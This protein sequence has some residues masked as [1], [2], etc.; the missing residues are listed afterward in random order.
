MIAHYI[1]QSVFVLVGILS[2]LA[3]VFNWE[4]F[5][6]AHNSQFIVRNLGRNKA[7]IFY[8]L[9]GIGMIAAGVYFF[10]SVQESLAGMK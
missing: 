4:W 7:R 1:I 2:I 6:T 8:A 9:L 5:F 3:S 10:L